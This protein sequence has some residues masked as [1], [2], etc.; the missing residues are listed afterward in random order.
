MKA[1]K[2]NL[3]GR[4]AFFKKP[5][6]NSY[7]YFTYGN[8]HKVAL[9]GIFGAILGYKGYNQMK[10]ED[11]YPEFYSRLNKLNIAIVPN[12]KNGIINKKVQLFNNSVG[13]A[14]KEA[15]GNLIVKEQWLEDPSWDIYLLLDCEESERVYNAITNNSFVFM[16]YL[17]KNDHIAEI[18][19]VEIYTADITTNFN[20]I[21]SFFYK[22][23]F[24][25]METE[26][27]PFSD[28]EIIPIFKYE[29]KLPIE[30]S[31][32]TNNYVL[33]SLVYTNSELTSNDNKSIYNVNGLNLQFI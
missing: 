23:D 16:P 13:Y 10:K 33:K 20:S 4:T 2:F 5:D 32:E 26:I 14:S 24:I 7:L 3:K 15:G 31:L 21:N 28:E 9:L 8:I 12:N 25:L 29:E 19:D 30:L 1:L 27:D 17:G 6:V 18:E 11:E 22:E